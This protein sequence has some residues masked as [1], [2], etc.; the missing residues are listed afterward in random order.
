MT[1]KKRTILHTLAVALPIVTLLP[2]LYVLWQSSYM[3]L[4]LMLSDAEVNK[5]AGYMLLWAIAC[6]GSMFISGILC[7]R[8]ARPICAAVC[9]LI[10]VGSIPMYITTDAIKWKSIG[11]IVYVTHVIFRIPLNFPL[12]ASLA[13]LMYTL[14]RFAYRKG[15]SFAARQ[16]EPRF[17][18]PRTWQQ[19]DLRLLILCGVTVLAAVMTSREHRFI[20]LICAVLWLVL[21]LVGAWHAANRRGHGFLTM[22]GVY[23]VV[24]IVAYVLH[25]KIMWRNW[26]LHTMFEQCYTTQLTP[27]GVLSIWLPVKST[28]QLALGLIA[29]L[30][31][32]CVVIYR[33][34]CWR[35]NRIDM[36]L[37]AGTS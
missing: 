36:S 25:T 21:W 17:Q 14:C 8:A 10:G 1:S 29:G 37:L 20:A 28:E 31:I 7:S 32:V 6:V 22:M 18:L 5:I 19:R 26:E 27:I 3:R 23:F 2:T 35:K 34:R 9:A 16:I 24:G 15:V 12:I 13:L 11:V 4:A 33:L 30:Y